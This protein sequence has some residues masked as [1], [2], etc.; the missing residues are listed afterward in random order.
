MAADCTSQKR[1]EPIRN[2]GRVA[3][4]RSFC[5]VRVMRTRLLVLAA[6]L[7][8]MARAAAAQNL[9]LAAASD[10]QAALPAIAA[11]FEKTSGRKVSL[12]FGSSGNFSAQIQNG[13]PFDVFLSA[14][15]DYP[16]R[17]ERAGLTEP[18]TLIEY[19][20]GRIV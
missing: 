14:D 1:L 2:P 12:T 20:R 13:A 4:I 11:E 19:A 15:V 18:G 17:L 6:L 10:L 7:V 3:Q 5:I 16:K 9:A 8:L